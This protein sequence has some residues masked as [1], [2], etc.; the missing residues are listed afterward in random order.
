[1]DILNKK[2]RFS[3][4][5]LFLL[6]FSITTGVLI[7]AL[8]FNFKLPL[9]ENEVL[10]QENDKMLAQANYQKKFSNEFGQIRKLVDSLQKTPEKFVYIEN[11]ITKK[12][13][14]LDKEMPDD[15]LSSRLYGR[16]IVNMQDLM[17]AKK[18]LLEN[19]DSSSKILELTNDKKDLQKRYDDL[20]IRFQMLPPSN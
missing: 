2:E 11:T 7:F 1:M 6:M 16:I 13:G 18:A 9:K 5:A 8:F 15:T 14:D 3:A 10:K 12:L 19:N 20:L 17:I 4:F